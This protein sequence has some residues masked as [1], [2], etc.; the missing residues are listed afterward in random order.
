[1]S[2]LNL[3]QVCQAKLTTMRQVLDDL[4]RK[5]STLTRMFHGRCKLK[6]EP[7]I[8]ETITL[9]NEHLT[10]KTSHRLIRQDMQV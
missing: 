3:C 4:D 6:A 9:V 7:E 5:I 8:G 1:M 10:K 2:I